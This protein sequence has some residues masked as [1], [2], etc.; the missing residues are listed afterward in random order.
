[1]F[2]GIIQ[3]VGALEK[4]ENS[5][6]GVKIEISLGDLASQEINHGDSISVNGTCLTVTGMHDGKVTFDVSTETLAKCLIGEWQPRDRVNLE[7]ALTMQT[8][9]GG[10]MVSG[11]VDG[12]GTVVE[13]VRSEEFVCMGLSVSSDLGKFI[14][15][16]GSVAVDGVSLTTNEVEDDSGITVFTVMLV[17]HTLANT[18]LELRKQGSRV[19]IEVDMASR[20]IN[21]MQEFQGR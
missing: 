19:H 3:A 6:S 14:A 17:P 9:L 4:I 18:T 12:P 1:M 13:M 7:L 15:P 2:T 10:H 5:A 8:R 21:R 16:K 20:Y 11:H